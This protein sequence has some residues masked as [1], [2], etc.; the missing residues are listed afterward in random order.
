MHQICR[1][2]NRDADWQDGTLADEEMNSDGHKYSRGMVETLH[3][4]IRDTFS[5]QSVGHTTLYDIESL[6]FYSLRGLAFCC[7]SFSTSSTL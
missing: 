7:Q 4:T 1:Q 3:C 2:G 6:N 5:T